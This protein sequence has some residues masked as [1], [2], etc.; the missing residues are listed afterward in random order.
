MAIKAP[1][2]DKVGLLKVNIQKKN[3]NLKYLKYTQPFLTRPFTVNHKSTWSKADTYTD[4]WVFESLVSRDA[5][6]WVYRQHL[7]DQILGFG[8]HSVPLRWWELK[9]EEETDD[10]LNRSSTSRRDSPL[11]HSWIPAFALLISE[12]THLQNP[13]I[14]V[15]THTEQKSSRIQQM[16]GT[17]QQDTPV[18]FIRHKQED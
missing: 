14:F 13:P 6:C 5:L 9:E 11:L 1:Q 16:N 15:K 3:H 4:P 18:P 12:Q 17:R 10:E 7:V 8:S 2:H